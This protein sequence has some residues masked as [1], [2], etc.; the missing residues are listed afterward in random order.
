MT[1]REIQV[2]RIIE[3]YDKINKRKLARL[4]DVSTGYSYHL[5]DYLADKDHLKKV[6][7]ETYQL[8]PKG[9]DALISQL[10][11]RISKLHVLIEKFSADSERIEKEIKRL[12]LR[13]ENLG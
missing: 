11:Y 9:V 1:P 13:K 5:L 6:G 10:Q 7:R 3:K 4:M 2:L 8:L 12:F